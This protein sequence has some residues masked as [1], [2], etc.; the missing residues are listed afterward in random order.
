MIKSILVALDGSEHSHAASQYALWLAEHLQ[1]TVTGLHVIDVVS[2]EGSGSFLHDISGSLGFEPYLDFSSKMR[3]AMQDRGRTLLDG[4]LTSCQER[5]IRADVQLATGIVA[6]EICEH[7]R[8][9]DIVIVVCCRNTTRE[10][11]PAR[12]ARTN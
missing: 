3:E 5:G 2:I 11:A 12:G 6:N 8:T 1:A 10:P 9:A 4:F 7:A